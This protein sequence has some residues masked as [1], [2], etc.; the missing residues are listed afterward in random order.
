MAG[1]EQL[2]SEEATDLLLACSDE[3]KELLLPACAAPS[4]ARSAENDTA[5][6]TAVMP[7]Q[8][9]RKSV[10]TLA[11]AQVRHAVQRGPHDTTRRRR[12]ATLLCK[13]TSRA[14]PPHTATDRRDPGNR[15]AQPPRQRPRTTHR[16]RTRAAV[17]R[18]PLTSRA[19]RSKPNRGRRPTQVPA[20]A[21]TQ[22][23]SPVY[24]RSTST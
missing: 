23:L 19:A 22:R 7:Q 4:P 2:G 3:H 8:L 14:K 12:R 20:H 1:C 17:A 10:Q 9:F 11:A 16:Q 13:K 24:F 18:S 21:M 6:F 5:R 15:R